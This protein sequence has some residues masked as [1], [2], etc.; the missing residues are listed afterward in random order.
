MQVV[1][2]STLWHNCHISGTVFNTVQCEP[3]IYVMKIQLKRRYEAQL[4][5]NCWFRYVFITAKATFTVVCL[6][7]TLYWSVL[8]GWLLEFHKC[9]W[10]VFNPLCVTDSRLVSSY[11]QHRI[12]LILVIVNNRYL[13]SILI[14]KPAANIHTLSCLT[15]TWDRASGPISAPFVLCNT[16][17]DYTASHCKGQCR[18]SRTP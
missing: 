18:C 15:R 7:P 6:L 13:F 2:A 8:A 3:S 5:S 1:N 10:V 11:F 9:S 16:T 17:H 14:T 12:S 4:S